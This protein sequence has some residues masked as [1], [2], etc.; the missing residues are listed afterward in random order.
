MVGWTNIFKNRYLE[1]NDFK[2]WF[3]IQIVENLEK[4]FSI[5]RRKQK[6][7]SSADLKMKLFRKLFRN[8]MNESLRLLLQKQFRFLHILKEALKLFTEDNKCVFLTKE[9]YQLKMC[10]LKVNFQQVLANF[11]LFNLKLIWNNT[12]WCF[13]LG[14][15]KNHLFWLKRMHNTVEAT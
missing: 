9:I 1:Q 5:F 10:F 2:K 7:N 3:K 13:R 11:F 12:C 15:F 8:W 4:G 14:A 6:Q